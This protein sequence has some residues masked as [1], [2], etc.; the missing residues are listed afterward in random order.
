MTSTEMLDTSAVEHQAYMIPLA[1]K[2]SRKRILEG[3]MHN[4]FVDPVDNM[5]HCEKFV[6]YVFA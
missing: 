5:I 4:R 2:Q 1:D 3:L 6:K